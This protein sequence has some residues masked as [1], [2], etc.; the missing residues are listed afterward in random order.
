MS[1]ASH[2]ARAE[3]YV[4]ANSLLSIIINET[5]TCDLLAI[6]QS[7][8]CDRLSAPLVRPVRHSVRAVGSPCTIVM[9]CVWFTALIIMICSVRLAHCTVRARSARRVARSDRLVHVAGSPRVGGGSRAT[10][11]RC[12]R[13]F[14]L[15]LA[16]QCALRTC[17]VSIS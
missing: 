7:S 2:R 10:T 4:V 13:R 1:E 3:G 16:M 8:A 14:G 5:E 15:S 9:S 11:P 12:A 6:Y 17:V